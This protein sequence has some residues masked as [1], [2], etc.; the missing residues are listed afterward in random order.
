M[1]VELAAGRLMARYLGQSLYT[2]TSVI[3]VVLAGIAAGNYAGGR[4]ADRFEARTA[5]ACAFV[6]SSLMCLVVPLWFRAVIGWA[7][8]WDL[9]WAFRTF[10]QAFGVFL[11]PAVALGAISPMAVRMALETAGQQGRTVGGLYA[12][13]AAGSLLGTFLAGFWMV[14]S[15][16]L[17]ACCW[18]S[19]PY[20][21]GRGWQLP[22]PD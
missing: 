3:G 20:C 12:W 11:L 8:L 19:P 6:V 13:G 22:E 9:S 4:I 2:W 21:C 14:A 10:L 1:A 18:E 15:L 17:R 16:F 5:L 7:S